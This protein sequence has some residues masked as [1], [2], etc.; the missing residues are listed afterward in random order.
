[1]F[2]PLSWKARLTLPRVNP[3]RLLRWGLV[4]GGARARCILL[5][6]GNPEGFWT[7][8]QEPDTKKIYVC[9][10]M[11]DKSYH[12]PCLRTIPCSPCNQD[13][14]E[15]SGS[16]K[17]Q[18]IGFP[19]SY[20]GLIYVLRNPFSDLSLLW[21]ECFNSSW[22]WAFKESSVGLLSPESL[23][24]HDQIETNAMETDLSIYFSF[25]YK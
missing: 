11:C 12:S 19:C 7:S 22:P 5:S 9:V 17:P 25:R 20:H 16:R 15:S 10:C 14:K 18:G 2:S 1:M 6:S 24:S 23:H 13:S 4:E 8:V 3:N 21:L